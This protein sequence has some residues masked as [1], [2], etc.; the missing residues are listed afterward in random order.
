ME[1]IKK[2]IVLFS[3]LLIS[4]GVSG[5]FIY[6]VII[7]TGDMKLAGEK[8]EKLKKDINDL[9]KTSP[10]PSK[11]NYEKITHDA[12][13]I[14]GKTKELQQIF[15]KPYRKA[16]TAM[17]NALGIKHDELIEL[18]KTTY[19]DEA[20]KGSPRELIY[21]RFFAKLEQNEEIGRDKV[22][23]A[24]KVFVDTVRAESVEPL[25]DANID[26]CIMEALGLPRKM[27]PIPCKRYML[28]M[29]DNLIQYML[30]TEN[31]DED[32]FVFG[33]G[34]KVDTVK[35][36]TFDKFEGAALPRPDE[37]SYIF[38]HLKLIEDLLI[39]LKKAGVQQLNA[40][41]KTSLKGETNTDYMVFTYTIKITAP[42]DAVRSFM[43][44][45]L[46]AYK[47]NRIYIVKSM[48]LSSEEDVTAIINSDLSANAMQQGGERKG[49]GLPSSAGGNLSKSNQAIAKVGVP[50]IGNNKAVT[51]EITFKYVIYIGDELTE[52]D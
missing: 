14:E 2:N 46:K 34:T 28:D 19:K 48:I 10:I 17:E 45:L 1:L 35:K 30:N 42:I 15:G 27:E 18:W 37:V 50:I 4:T 25:N 44:S 24:K 20:D 47:D 16:V 21:N 33:T 6:R 23:K 11:K 3:L 31:D 38:K 39:R 40:I 5:F 8:V 9:N 7:E 49:Y 32:P 22:K 29:Q 51:A 26:G 52:N 41:T 36:L 43:N 12:I 13:V